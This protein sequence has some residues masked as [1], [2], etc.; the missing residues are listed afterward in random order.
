MNRKKIISLMLLLFALFSGVNYSVLR[1]SSAYELDV[2]AVND[3]AQSLSKQWEGLNQANLPGLEYGLDYSVLNKDGICIASTKSGLSTDVASA[4]R[5]RDTMIDIAKKDHVL[6]KLIICNNLKGKWMEEKQTIFLIY[7]LVFFLIFT[8]CILYI[9]II[10][11]RILLPF[12]SLK[13][14]AKQVAEGNLELPLTMD[15]GNMF[16]AFTESFDL[17]REELNRAQENERLANQSKKELVASLSHDIKTPVASIIAVSEIMSVKSKDESVKEQL[18]TII[19]KAD[20][21]NS[22]ITNM[23]HATLEELQELKVVVTEQSSKLLPGL[24]KKADYSKKSVITKIED[25]I[26]LVDMLRLSQVI[27]NVI[28]NSYKYAGTPIEVSSRING[29]YLEL[30]FQDYGEGVLEEELPFLINKFYRATNSKGKNGSGLGLY[31][32]KYLMKHMD[33]D[34]LCKSTPEGFVVTIRLK[35]AGMI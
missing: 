3:I 32:S 5:N 4:I 7:E 24:I 27:D 20:Q 30:N 14:F 22:L 15:R 2:V 8:L 33:G 13:S 16:G 19:D 10:D 6:G 34:L 26:I 23:F 35:L 1:N 12:R 31:I 9:Y 25:G 11:K 28:S 29:C 18:N 17:M 21:I